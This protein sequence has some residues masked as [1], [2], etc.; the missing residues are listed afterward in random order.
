MLS[1]CFYYCEFHNYYILHYYLKISTNYRQIKGGLT[2]SP[3]CCRSASF[4]VLTDTTAT[5]HNRR[6][7]N[8][9]ETLV[10]EIHTGFKRNNPFTILQPFFKCHDFLFA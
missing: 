4:L 1:S 2:R 5:L 9:L 10:Q 8:W 3:F 6:R 7:R